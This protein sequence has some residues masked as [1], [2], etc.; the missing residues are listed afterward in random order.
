MR[1]LVT[2][3]M[4]PRMFEVTFAGMINNRHAAVEHL[5]S[6]GMVNIEHPNPGDVLDEGANDAY[7]AMMEDPEAKRVH[8]AFY[9]NLY[10][11]GF[12]RV[13]GDKAADGPVSLRSVLPG[14]SREP[15]AVPKPVYEGT[16]PELL[17][18]DQTVDALQHRLDLLYGEHGVLA[19]PPAIIMAMYDDLAVTL[20][21]LA[22]TKI[23]NKTEVW[24]LE[25]GADMLGP[26]TAHMGG[27]SRKK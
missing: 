16:L 19:G 10:M 21:P 17:N 4:D 7:A 25:V 1:E 18:N 12:R 24:Q 27:R 15:S 3:W 5:S 11:G 2:D 13:F 6:M 20:K 22:R 8:D 26:T 14:Q 9:L 23:Q